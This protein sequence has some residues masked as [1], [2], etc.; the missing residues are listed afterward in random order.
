MTTPLRLLLVEDSDDDMELLLRELRRGAYEPDCTRV[1]TPGDFL[2]ALDRRD[3]DIVISDFSM[4]A[5]SGLQALDLLKQKALD[6]PFILIS[7]TVGEETAVECMKAGAHDYL[8][9]ANLTRLVPAVARELRE[10]AERR[11]R[12]RAESA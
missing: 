1:Q 10:A 7:G 11:Q 9:K 5:F 4:P 3:W 6:V 12:R 2:S 8:M